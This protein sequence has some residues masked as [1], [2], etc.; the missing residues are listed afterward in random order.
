MNA[1]IADDDPKALTIFSRKTL[2]DQRLATMNGG[3][4]LGVAERVWPG[5]RNTEGA[6]Q[7]LPRESHA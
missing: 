5:R 4:V 3:M 2:L 7:S 6:K 1:L